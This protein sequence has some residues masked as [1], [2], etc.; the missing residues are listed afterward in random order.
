MEAVVLASMVSLQLH[1]ADY[2]LADLGQE[3]QLG[4]DLNGQ[5]VGV[6][7]QPGAQGSHYIL[8]VLKYKQV[9]WFITA[10]KMESSTILGLRHLS[11]SWHF[12]IEICIYDV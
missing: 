7:S 8:E 3:S 12:S 2:I 6:G 11:I 1:L 5:L 9:K 10:P 4:Q